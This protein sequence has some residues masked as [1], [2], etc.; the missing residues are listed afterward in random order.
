[1][2]NPSLDFLRGTAVILVLF[3]H[4]WIGVDWLQEI[5]WI[6]VDLFFVLSGFLVSGLLFKEYQRAG[7]I[8]PLRFLIRRGFKIYPMFYL[9]LA[10]TY[11]VLPFT[12]F[13]NFENLNPRGK[14]LAMI[15]EPLFLQN[16]FGAIWAHHWS[17]AVEEHFYIGLALL[18]PL[19]VKHIRFVPLVM[20]ACLAMRY[21][22]DQEMI[23]TRTHLRIDSLLMGVLI[24]YVWHFSDPKYWYERYKIAIHTLA[25]L[26]L[27]AAVFAPLYLKFTLLY[28]AFGAILVTLQFQ[29]WRYP[30]WITTIGYYSYGIYLF[31]LYL[32]VFIVG[33]TYLFDEPQVFTWDTV[34]SFLIFFIGSIA[35]GILMSKFIEKPFLALRERFTP[36]ASSPA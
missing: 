17:L 21:F 18:F 31:H 8:R 32:I 1:M 13:P 26:P 34:P 4:H 16:Y 7:E 23:L 35:I 11:A 3:R 14:T 29:T 19:L 22:S 15:A 12:Q 36:K 6:G 5:G 24:S 10:V 2:R 27:I 33:P 20:V 30:K 28:I 9:S 25:I